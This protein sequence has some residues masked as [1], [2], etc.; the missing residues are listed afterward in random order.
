MVLI[1]DGIS[2]YGM[3]RL[4]KGTIYGYKQKGMTTSEIRAKVAR[5]PI[6]ADLKAKVNYYL[7]TQK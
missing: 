2:K 4:I 3:E 6:S 5:Y 1:S 7:Q